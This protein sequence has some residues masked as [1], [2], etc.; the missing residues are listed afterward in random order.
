MS[1]DKFYIGLAD[2]WAAKSKDRSTK[3]GAV[4]V[5]PDHE[6][7]SSGFNG[8]PRKVDDTVDCRHDRPLKYDFT[9]HAETNAIY[10]AARMGTST[11]GCV[12]YLN[13]WPW[14]CPN[15]AGAIIQSGI[16]TVIG[17]DRPFR[18]NTA[19]TLEDLVND[20]EPK[21]SPIDW[22]EAFVATQEMFSE[23]HIDVRVVK[24]NSALSKYIDKLGA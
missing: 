9:V 22:Q 16:H 5:G 11:N 19:V 8:F 7:R 4:I 24:M 23:A 2:Q 13:W 6:Q 18:S 10:N 12:L 3:V 17:P 20:T 1:W 21:G 15:C 14:P